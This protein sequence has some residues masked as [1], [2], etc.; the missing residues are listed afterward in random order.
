MPASPALS[1]QA[2]LGLA[3][4]RNARVRVVEETATRMIME[5]ERIYPRWL[6][7]LPRWLGARPHRTVGLDGMAL[8]VW[9]R[10]DDRR[11]LGEHVD[12]LAAEEQLGFNEARLIM[13]QFLHSLALKGLVV[14]GDRTAPLVSPA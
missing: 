14:L 9:R 6:G 3:V 2:Q 7:P 8:Q 13:L 11:T 4:L 10:V 1:P 5:V 12:W